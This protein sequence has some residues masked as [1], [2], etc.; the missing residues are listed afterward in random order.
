[1]LTVQLSLTLVQTT[2]LS[3]AIT[4]EE[5][6]ADSFLVDNPSQKKRA[7]ESL[8]VSTLYN[9]YFNPCNK[10]RKLHN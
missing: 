10:K 9:H 2:P 4:E 3:A 7:E 5:E 1:M 6:D 8:A